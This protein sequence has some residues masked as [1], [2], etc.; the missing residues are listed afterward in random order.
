MYASAIRGGVGFS[1]CHRQD[2]RRLMIRLVCRA[3]CTEYCGPDMCAS[4]FDDL[5][6]L[7]YPDAQSGELYIS[8]PGT[9]IAPKLSALVTVM[10]SEGGESEMVMELK[11]PLISRRSLET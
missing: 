1:T 10:L 9:L 5:R 3:Y 6:S 2:E 7:P 8:D 4:A 11:M